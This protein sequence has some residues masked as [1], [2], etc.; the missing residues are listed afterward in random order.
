MRGLYA[1][2][3]FTNE[4]RY[5][6]AVAILQELQASPIDVINLYPDLALDNTEDES[7]E[8]AEPSGEIS[9]L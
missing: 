6:E 4:K 9:L 7:I 3:I 8:H 1:H 5:S 2:H